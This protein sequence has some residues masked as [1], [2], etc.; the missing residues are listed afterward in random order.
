M[1]GQLYLGEEERYSLVLVE[2]LGMRCIAVVLEAVGHLG[3]RQLNMGPRCRGKQNMKSH[4][5]SDQWANCK[6]TSLLNIYQYGLFTKSWG[7]SITYTLEDCYRYFLVGDQSVVELQGI[8]LAVES[9]SVMEQVVGW[10][11]YEE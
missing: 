8:D 6:S 10:K 2:L 3:E 7:V 1:V 11:V 5:G 4:G 9:E